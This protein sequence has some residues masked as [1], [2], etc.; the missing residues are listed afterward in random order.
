MTTSAPNPSN[1]DAGTR[2]SWYVSASVADDL[3]ATV[4]QVYFDLRGA[5]S[6]RV[7]LDAILRTGLAHL[8]EARKRVLEPPGAAGE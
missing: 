3:A 6:K 8:D 5:H 1:D 2:R 7:I 4:D